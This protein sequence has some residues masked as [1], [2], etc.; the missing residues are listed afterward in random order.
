ML[1]SWGILVLLLSIA[2]VEKLSWGLRALVKGQGYHLQG[3]EIQKLAFGHFMCT[4]ISVTKGDFKLNV[5]D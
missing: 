5:Q 3:P 2:E 1:L 4:L